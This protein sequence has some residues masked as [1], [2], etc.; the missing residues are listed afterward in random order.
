M[1]YWR[2][3]LTAAILAFFTWALATFGK[4]HTLL[5]DRVYPYVTRLVQTMLA[6]WSAD[7]TFCLWQL[8]A[9]LLVVVI[10]ASLVIF[11]VM[12]WN[13][14]QWLGWV[15][16]G[17][18][19]LAFLHTAIYG[20]NSYAGPL[21]DDIRL[22]VTDYTLQE[23]EEAT[24]YYR[25][26]ANAL[27]G[28]INRDADGKP[29]FSDFETLANQA[30]EGYQSLV[31]NRH[32]AVFAGST[33]P[34]KQLDWADTYTSMQ[35][36]GFTLSLTG[37]AAVNPQMPVVGMPFT[38]CHEMAHRMCI[39]I[40]RDANFAAFLACDANESVEFQYSAYFSAY[41]YCYNALIGLNATQAAQR[42][43]A[44]VGDLLRQDLADYR[45]FFL[46]HKDEKAE[47]V[48]ETINDSYIKA[49]GDERGT[50]SYGD[51][52]DLLVCWYIQE[53]VLPTQT[54]DEEKFDPYDEG[55]VFA[56]VPTEPAEEPKN[57]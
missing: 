11:I 40:E 32:M 25:D 42:V 18:T 4:N 14:V 26:R 22:E 24:T 55:W 38:M 44:G 9:I 34:V 46:E 20:L 19:I 13:L 33:A 51:V 41:R 52:T 23:L 29:L 53:Q 28:Q 7:V 12:K 31:F 5:I 35:I 57:E 3:Y 43:S 2:G 56:T 8:V 27:S 45:D 36:T 49:N 6:D 17:A 21:A 37:E 1:K 10:L 48:A 30:G 54:E 39:A 50:A 47:K 15:L 16:T